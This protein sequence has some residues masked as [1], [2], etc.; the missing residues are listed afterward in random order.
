M[1]LMSKLISG[2]K[3]RLGGRRY[4]NFVYDSVIEIIVESIVCLINGRFMWVK[5]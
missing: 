1:F 2:N 4:G 3:L 5:C